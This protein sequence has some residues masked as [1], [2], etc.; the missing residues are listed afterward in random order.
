MESCLQFEFA[1]SVKASN[2]EQMSFKNPIIM[3]QPTRS[4]DV[5]EL[6]S[7]L[8]LTGDENHAAEDP[9]L[10]NTS[11]TLE[12]KDSL[13]PSSIGKDRYF[14]RRVWSRSVRNTRNASGGIISTALA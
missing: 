11:S 1:L 14:N 7:G 2:A 5:P 13:R 10:N 9:S 12:A 8:I 3:R 4:L 6:D